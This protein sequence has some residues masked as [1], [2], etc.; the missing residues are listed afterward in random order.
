MHF[1]CG[2]HSKE[3]SATHIIHAAVGTYLCRL[4][5]DFNYLTV[6]LVR[7]RHA[8][9][10]LLVC[11]EIDCN[12]LIDLIHFDLDTE[13]IVANKYKHNVVAFETKFG[14]LFWQTIVEARNGD[15]LFYESDEEILQTFRCIVAKKNI[16]ILYE[17]RT[18]KEEFCVLFWRVDVKTRTIRYLAGTKV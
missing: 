11:Q 16:R 4:R 18:T 6:K 17:T 8:V 12:V 10:T 14:C 15:E 7:K 3:I 1:D 9:A 2:K 5:D 13:V